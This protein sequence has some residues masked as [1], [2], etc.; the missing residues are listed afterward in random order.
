MTS[1]MVKVCTSIL[2]FSDEC[3]STGDFQVDTQEQDLM[4]VSTQVYS[5]YRLYEGCPI[6]GLIY[7]KLDY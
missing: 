4:D 3:I 2:C 6:H 5:H 7:C 1:P